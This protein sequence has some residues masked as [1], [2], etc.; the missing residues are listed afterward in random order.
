M[1]PGPDNE[2]VDA[3]GKT[4]DRDKFLNMLKEYYHLRGWDKE[5]GFPSAD[6]LGKLGLQDLASKL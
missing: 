5:T 4:L 6:T 2:T 1:V 3:S